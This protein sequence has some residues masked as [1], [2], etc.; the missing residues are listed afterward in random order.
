MSK[1]VSQMIEEQV[2][3][4]MRNSNVGKVSKRLPKKSPVITVSREFGAKGAALAAKLGERLGYKVW[5]RD[6][7]II[8]SEKLGSNEEFI[9]SLDEVRRGFLEDTIF[10]F[11]RQRETNLHYLIYLVRAVRTLEKYGNS[12]I[13]GRGA[14]YICQDPKSFHIRVVSPLKTRIERYAKDQNMPKEKVLEVINKK[15]D[16][17]ANFVEYNFNRDISNSSDYDLVLNSE[18]YNLEEMTDIILHAYEL[19]TGKKLSEK[20]KTVHA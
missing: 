1:K 16:E 6:L 11:L 2:L 14:N 8:I 12:I 20:L 13:V 19:K 3:F 10:G 4:W 9:K 15:D 18:T 17:R 7:L 5:D